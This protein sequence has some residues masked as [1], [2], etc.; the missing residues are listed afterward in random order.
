MIEF[1]G[2]R[3]ETYAYLM[4]DDNEHKK[5]KGR[6]KCVIQKRLMFKNYN[7]D[8]LNNKI[9]Y[10]HNKDLKTIIIMYTVNKSTRLH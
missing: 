5:A 9:I 10:N 8:L 1:V 3:A 6:K 2:L 7:D 4:D